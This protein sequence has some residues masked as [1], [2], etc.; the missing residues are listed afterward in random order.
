VLYLYLENATN[1]I[2]RKDKDMST[3]IKIEIDK[4]DVYRV[5]NWYKELQDIEKAIA[6]MQENNKSSLEKDKEL[7]R[8]NDEYQ[9]IRKYR[10]LCNDEFHIK[11]SI[12][13][14]KKSISKG[15]KI[16]KGVKTFENAVQ[17]LHNFINTV[18]NKVDEIKSYD[19]WNTRGSVSTYVHR[20]RLF[21]YIVS[22]AH[23]IETNDVFKEVREYVLI[24]KLDV[25][26]L[27]EILSVEVKGFKDIAETD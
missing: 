19:D 6:E 18:R 4:E 7:K 23:E 2:K 16:S 21:A 5:V 25:A 26:A 3:K 1:T 22:V 9:L 24:R 8:M 13:Y 17:Y 12:N 20:K 11:E 10:N 14:V 27:I 15:S